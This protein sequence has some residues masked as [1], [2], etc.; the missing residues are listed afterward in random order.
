MASY[1]MASYTAFHTFHTDARSS[2]ATL[3]ASVRL[4]RFLRTYHFDK[5]NDRYFD[6][7]NDRYFDKL[8]DR[9]FGKL[10]DPDFDKLN[11]H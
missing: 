7:L 6:K 2:E 9:Y 11:N 4:S 1:T 10:N 3:P 8:N 5:L